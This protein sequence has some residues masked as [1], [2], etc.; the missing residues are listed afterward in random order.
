MRLYGDSNDKDLH[1][2]VFFAVDRVAGLACPEKVKR[3]S[4]YPPTNEQTWEPEKE[5]FQKGKWQKSSKTGISAWDNYGIRVFSGE[6]SLSQPPGF[7]GW[8]VKV[9]ELG[10]RRKNAFLMAERSTCFQTT[11]FGLN[12]PFAEPRLH[13]SYTHCKSVNV[14]CGEWHQI[15]WQHIFM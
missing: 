7:K 11:K 5:P 15:T 10:F 1:G 6:S 12:S 8:A 4:M 13:I 14:Y 2:T 3:I 9:P